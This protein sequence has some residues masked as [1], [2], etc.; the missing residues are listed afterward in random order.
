MSANAPWI[1]DVTE[2]NFETEVLQKSQQIPIIIDF[3]A[4]WCGPCQQLAPMLENVINEFQGKVQ[5]AKINIDEQ[6]GLAA[7]FRVQSIP[8]VV[9]FLN[10]QPVDHFQGILPEE[11]LREWVTQLVPSPLD[12]LL[13]EGQIL[14]ETDPAAAE[15]KYRE[16]A[17]LDPKNDTIK[18]R[19]AAVLVKL[20]RFDEC[21][22]IIEEL[23]ARGFLEPEA[24]QIKSQLELQAAADEAGG[25]EEARKALEA[26]PDNADLK[27][28]LADALAI[29]NKHEEALEICLA[30]IAEDKAGAGVEAKATMLRI[31][32]LLGPQS[33]LTS[34]YRRKLATLLY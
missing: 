16:A 19:L 23:E 3:W 2:E 15:G 34:A 30:I 8:T 28:A 33:A 4:P 6:Q 26:D 29:S 5:L 14:E 13:Q 32:D 7:A 24:E 12:M 1:I 25:V 27:I 20:S 9:A 31:F 18:L 10:G 11:S 21:G 17:E 22:Q